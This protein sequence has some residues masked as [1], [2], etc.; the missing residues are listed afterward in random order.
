MF[1]Y[2]LDASPLSDVWFANIFSYLWLVH[3]FSLLRMEVFSV[4][5]AKFINFCLSWIV[6]SV[7]SLSNNSGPVD[8]P[9]FFQKFYIV[10][11]IW[12]PFKLV[13]VEGGKSE[14]GCTF[15]VWD[16]SFSS[17]FCGKTIFPPQGHL[18]SFI[19]DWWPLG[20]PVCIVGRG[21]KLLQR[22]QH[23]PAL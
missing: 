17:S 19:G 11:F 1:V 13:F 9:V 7:S 2:I 15:H 18:C 5:S 4:T 20:A 12:I 14:S 16:S 21:A 8:S 3:S 10:V 6:L 22:R 23:Q